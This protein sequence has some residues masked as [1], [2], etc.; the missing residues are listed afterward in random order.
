MYER[1]SP[2]ASLVPL[3]PES[4]RAYHYKKLHFSPWLTHWENSKKLLENSSRR[5]IGHCHDCQERF[6][7][8]KLN[9]L[10]CIEILFSGCF[11]VVPLRISC[12]MLQNHVICFK[13]TI[14]VMWLFILN[15]CVETYLSF[16]KYIYFCLFGISIWTSKQKTVAPIRFHVP[17]ARLLSLMDS[18]QRWRHFHTPQSR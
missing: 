8:E 6:P 4:V 12:A 14:C 1:Q 5:H 2:W 18:L 10:W 3:K 11:H 7:R 9:F 16:G 15:S 13:S 17:L